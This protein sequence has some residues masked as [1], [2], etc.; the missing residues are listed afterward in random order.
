MNS[1][2]EKSVVLEGSME[3]MGK[4]GSVNL[5]PCDFGHMDVSV[6]ASEPVK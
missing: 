6:A 2:E 3:Y 5:L 4:T 1:Q